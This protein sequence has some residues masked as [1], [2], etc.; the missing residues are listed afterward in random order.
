MTTKWDDLF[1][2]DFYFVVTNEERKYMGLN[3]LESG[4]DVSQF[5]SKTNLWHKRTSVFWHGDTIKK[6]IYEEKRVSNNKITYERIVEYDTELLTENREWLLPLNERGKKKKVTATNILAITPFGCEFYFFID[7]ARTETIVAMGILNQRNYKEITIGEEDKINKI[8]NDADF[9]EFMKYYME[10]CPSDYFDKIKALRENEHVTVKY[11]AGDVFR[12]ELDRFHYGYGIITGRIKEILKWDEL[13]KKH[14]LRTAMMVPVMIRF[15]DICTTDDNL[16]VEE[17][18]GMPL[19]RVEICA[20]NDIIWGRH[21]IIGHK[22]LQKEDIEFNLICTKIQGLNDNIT[23]HTYDF[24][25]SSGISEYPD[26]FDLYV[27]WGT[28]AT[29]LPFEQISSEL[30]EYLHEYSSPHGGVTM[31]INKKESSK[32][33]L[34]DDINKEMRQELF[35]CL[36]LNPDAEFD[37]FANKYGGL[38]KEEILKK[39]L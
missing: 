35:R 25:V 21:E 1:G 32:Y 22:E 37:E 24:F 14:S 39:K 7:A 28:A 11:K 33:N 36:N 9:H 23:V 19:G 6:V 2:Q 4:W 16:S 26:S 30:K 12:V 31:G 17:L 10:T 13:P 3:P 27:E 5:Y 18:S 15:Y 8:K 34:L 29:I 20:D 38:T